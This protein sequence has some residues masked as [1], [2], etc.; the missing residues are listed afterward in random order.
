MHLLTA[1]AGALQ[2][3]G[4]AI[5]LGQTPGAIV[6]ASAADSELALIAG[7]VDRA[8]VR[9]VRLANLLRLSHNMS[10]DLWI[11]QTVQHAA[12]WLRIAASPSNSRTRSTPRIT[13]QRGWR[14]SGF[15]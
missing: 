8:G 3:E 13:P 15:W 1:Q 12:T 5:D 4:E 9:D 6:F 14:G 2:Q 11:E 10:V 7:A